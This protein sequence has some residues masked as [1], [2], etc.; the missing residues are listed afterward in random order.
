MQQEGENSR[1][2]YSAVDAKQR[3]HTPRSPYGNKSPAAANTTCMRVR[4]A[5]TTYHPQ[6]IQRNIYLLS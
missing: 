1:E 3:T 2:Y 4:L 6:L 5:D